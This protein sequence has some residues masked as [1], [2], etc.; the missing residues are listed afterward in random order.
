MHHQ[1]DILRRIVHRADGKEIH[2]P[3]QKTEQVFQPA[4]QLSRGRQQRDIQAADPQHEGGKQPSL[5]G[6][7]RQQNDQESWEQEDLSPSSAW[8]RNNWSNARIAPHGQKPCGQA[9][10]PQVGVGQAFLILPEKS[11]AVS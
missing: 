2:P 3:L 5:P 9:I 4:L 6:Q 1:L 7:D 8:K 10:Q 11:V